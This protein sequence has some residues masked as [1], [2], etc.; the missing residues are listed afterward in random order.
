MALSANLPYCQSAER[1]PLLNLSQ[2]RISL[3]A[4]VD[5]SALAGRYVNR[6]ES[7]SI[8]MEWISPDRKGDISLGMAAGAG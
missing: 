8:A 1:T 2:G 7:R 3:P 6:P 5:F 4:S